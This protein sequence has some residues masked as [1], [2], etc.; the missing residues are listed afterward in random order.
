MSGWIGSCVERGGGR[1]I[2][3]IGQSFNINPKGGRY[4][5]HDPLIHMT[6]KVTTACFR[7]HMISVLSVNLSSLSTFCTGN[8]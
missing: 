1:G 8:N 2:Y 7:V 3:N 4:C 6:L 5:Y